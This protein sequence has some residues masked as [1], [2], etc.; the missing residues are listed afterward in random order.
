MGATEVLGTQAWV[1]T[2]GKGL[3]PLLW[4][5]WAQGDMPSGCGDM[6]GGTWC[7]LCIML[8]GVLPTVNWGEHETPDEGRS[9]NAKLWNVPDE[10]G[11]DH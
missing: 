8:L 5:R 1:L 10:R 3:L 6:L 2:M 11:Q 4:G 7:H 9:L